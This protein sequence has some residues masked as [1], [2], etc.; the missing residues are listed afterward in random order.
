MSICRLARTEVKAPV[1]GIVSARGARIGAIASAGAGPLF[2][3]IRDGELE[4]RADVAETDM[5]RIVEG[6][7]VVHAT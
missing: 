4:L 1:S 5:H 2:S 6:Q 7:S 3:I